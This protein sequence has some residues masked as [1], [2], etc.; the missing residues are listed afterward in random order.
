MIYYSIELLVAAGVKDILIVCGGNAAGEFL[1]ILGNG[2][3]FGLRHLHYTYQSEPRGIADALGLAEEFVGDDSM[4]V[5]LSDNLFENS[6]KPHIDKYKLEPDGA[7]I[8]GS[9]VEHP[10]HYGVI[11][12]DEF[13]NVIKISE[14]P[15]EPKSN[16]IATG[17]YIYDNTVWDFIKSL[18][19]SARG[20][21]EIT[22]VN[23]HYLSKGKLRLTEL[24]GFW[25]DCG[26]NID[27][28]FEA[29]SKAREMSKKTISQQIHDI[30]A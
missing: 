26:E 8:F 6:I 28:Y 12:Q 19:P 17:L 18:Q 24:T 10:Q 4:C 14:K 27:G 30:P 13:G 23:N 1:R 5:I 29:C 2:E 20:E 22:D 9:R 3:Q 25:A 11:E 16:L 15:K 21:L 7:M